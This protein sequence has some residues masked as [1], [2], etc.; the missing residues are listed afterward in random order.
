[1]EEYF[2]FQIPNGQIHVYVGGVFSR[3]LRWIF[4]RHFKTETQTSTI[5][6]IHQRGQST[7][8][9]MNNNMIINGTSPVRIVN[10]Q[11]NDSPFSYVFIVE[12]SK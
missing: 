6:D 4:L 1:M 9:T 5:Y 12:Y 8:I 3:V 10:V 2:R 7:F 11:L